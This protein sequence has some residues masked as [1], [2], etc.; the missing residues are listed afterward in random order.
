MADVNGKMPVKGDAIYSAENNE[1]NAAG[2][3]TSSRSAA[4][5]EQT[6]DKRPTSVAGDDDKI[7]LDVAI[8]LGDGS[9]V[10]KD[11][12]VPMYMTDSP[13]TEIEDY[14]VDALLKNGGTANHDYLTTSEFRGLHAEGSSAG[15]AKFELQVEDAPAAGTFSTIMTKFNSVANPTVEFSHKS[16]APVP[17]GV[18]IRMVKTNL[19][20][21]DTDVYSLINGREV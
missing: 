2:L 9:G 5:S 16:P 1:P 7:A 11:N 3:V 8:S 6:M 19:D 20:N 13:A 12:P 15:L 4:I 10:D 21:N 18:I 17:T 14:S